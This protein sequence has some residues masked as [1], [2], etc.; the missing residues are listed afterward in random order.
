MGRPGGGAFSAPLP[1]CGA[2]PQVSGARPRPPTLA[3]TQVD[4]LSRLWAPR[5]VWASELSLEPEA[6]CD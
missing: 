5:E 4:L 3:F 1:A 6:P 2:S